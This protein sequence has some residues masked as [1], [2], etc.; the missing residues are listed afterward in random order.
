M[1]I[2]HLCVGTLCGGSME[3]G[4]RGVCAEG[5]VQRD[6]KCDS[7]GGEGKKEKGN[8]GSNVLFLPKGHTNFESANHLVTLNSVTCL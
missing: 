3:T 8:T 1:Q 6:N 4:S 2:A 5:Y 7:R